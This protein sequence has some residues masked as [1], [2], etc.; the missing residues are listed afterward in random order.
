MNKD[1][2]YYFTSELIKQVSNQNCSDEFNDFKTAITHF[3]SRCADKNQ[4]IYRNSKLHIDYLCQDFGGEGRM[5]WRHNYKPGSCY[6]D[7]LPKYYW[8]DGELELVSITE[9][10]LVEKVMKFNKP[11]IDNVVRKHLNFTIE[12]IWTLNVLN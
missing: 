6:S 4:S 8:G 2:C 10:T 5:L 11:R 1:Y 7:Y 9:K 12:Y 3:T